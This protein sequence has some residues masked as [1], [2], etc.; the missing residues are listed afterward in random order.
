MLMTLCKDCGCKVPYSTT[1]CADCASKREEYLKSKNKK[2]N[3]DRYNRDKANE[4]YRLFYTTKEWYRKREEIYKLYEGHCVIC[5]ALY[6]FNPIEEIHHIEPL[7]K[8][9]DKRL[10]NDNLI[11]LC[12]KCHKDIHYHK[13]DNKDKLEKYIKQKI[14]SDRFLQSLLKNNIQK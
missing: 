2:Y 5:R 10:D 6:K 3:A 11:G 13:I 1:R 7:L 4:S 8:N 9:Y 14:N 12:S